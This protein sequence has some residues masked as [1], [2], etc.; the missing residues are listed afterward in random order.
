[1]DCLIKFNHSENVYPTYIT[2]S[3]KLETVSIIITVQTKYR[4]FKIKRPEA[5]EKCLY[6]VEI[7]PRNGKSHH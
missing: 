1:M 3:H 5:E 2:S 4:L 6:L 7:F